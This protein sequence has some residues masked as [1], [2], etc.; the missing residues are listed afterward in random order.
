LLALEA[1]TPAANFS[2]SLQFAKHASRYQK[3]IA[4]RP[5]RRL[6]T[7]PLDDFAMWCRH[8]QQDVPIPRGAD[9]RSCPR[10]H[11]PLKQSTSTRDASVGISDCGVALEAFD[12][13]PDVPMPQPRL[14]VDVPRDLRRLERL[15][16]PAPRTVLPV[17]FDKV[18]PVKELCQPELSATN[19]SKNATADEQ[20]LFS[21]VAALLLTTGVTAFLCGFALLVTATQLAH[22]IAWRWG[23]A[24]TT[25]SQALLLAASIAAL[26]RLHQSH[27]RLHKQIDNMNQRLLP[28]L[29]RGQISPIP[30]P[31]GRAENSPAFQRLGR[32]A[33][34]RTCQSR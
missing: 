9:S 13:A 23:F 12:S 22:A 15:L 33:R 16:R 5:R 18:T 25:A 29:D 14:N 8:C 34:N 2:L 32:A 3:R 26:V 11:H 28:T 4:A 7:A 10:C 24:I 6:I 20:P 30:V 17:R 1:S 31:E 27:R 19:V 21:G